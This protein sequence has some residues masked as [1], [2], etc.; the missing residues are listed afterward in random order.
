M[1]VALLA[2]RLRVEER[3]LMEAFSARGH[4]A[5][6]HTPAQISIPLTGGTPRQFD[7]LTL[8]RGV[9][10]I[11]Q[12]MLAALLA[13]NGTAVVNRPATSRLLADRLALLRHLIIAGI[14]VPE[15][16]VS[17]G[18]E[19]TFATIQQLGYPVL[20]KSVAVDPAFPVALVEDEDA[21]EA[22]VEH[23]MML[24]GER[25]VLVQRF[26][27]GPGHSVRVTI[28]GHD[29]LGIESRVHSGWRPA[30]DA[31]YTEHSD[32]GSALSAL[33]T[34]VLERLGTGVYSIE[35]IEADS[36]PVVV[37]TSNLVD[38]RSLA[39]HGID[40][41]GAI[42]DFSLTQVDQQGMEH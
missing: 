13:A 3:L 30:R 41:A 39:E 2:N 40:V 6:I 36:G 8:D 26:V 23:R 7:P 16:V 10:T 34:T 32:T 17:F 20:L 24:G 33:A 1:Q 12:T 29:I 38:F 5:A 19:S 25:A 18:E 27:E 37:G 14:P 21:A 31:A 9:S 15:T 22:I 35:V 11:E 42:A 28:V 4:E